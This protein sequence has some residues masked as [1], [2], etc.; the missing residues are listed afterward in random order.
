MTYAI[1]ENKIPAHI[2]S[3]PRESQVRIISITALYQ[4]WIEYVEDGNTKKAGQCC[5]QYMQDI[6][7]LSLKEQ[8][9]HNELNY[10]KNVDWTK[11]LQEIE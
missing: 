11:Q 8:Q 2:K 6:K 1:N 4:R 3:L 7:A 5:T 10:A 9:L